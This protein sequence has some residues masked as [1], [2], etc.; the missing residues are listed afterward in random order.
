VKRLL[1]V[2]GA[3]LATACAGGPGPGDPGYAYNVEGRYAGRLTVDGT[4][5]DA[6]FDLRT[7]GAGRV[8]G[9]FRVQ[10]PIEVEGELS[11]RILDNLL[12]A[13]VTWQGSGD[14]SGRNCTSVVE[15]ILT[16]SPGGA[17]V[18]GPVTISDCGDTLSG[19][20]SFRRAASGT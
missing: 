6:A 18:D 1:A 2:A 7:T 5:F 9:T 19:R 20:M 12:R 3:L 16:I 10:A 14:G 13:T 15:G 17:V 4:P 8:Y 11:G